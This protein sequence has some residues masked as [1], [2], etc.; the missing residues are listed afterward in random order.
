MPRRRIPKVFIKPKNSRDTI[1]STTV[2]KIN[3]QAS[4]V[5]PDKNTQNVHGEFFSESSHMMKDIVFV[6]YYTFN[7][8]YETEAAKLKASLKKLNLLHDIVP[9]ASV[10]NWQDN[11]RFKAKFLQQM[12]VK[13]KD[14]NLAL[15]QLTLLCI[16]IAIFNPKIKV[17]R[18][19]Y[20]YI[21]HILL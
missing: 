11:T 18:N 8:P 14:K 6:A 21:F 4:V 15:L 20:N 13:H 10:G 5:N 7:T 17:T 16:L 9:I 2:N 3:R 12:L 19:I 1:E